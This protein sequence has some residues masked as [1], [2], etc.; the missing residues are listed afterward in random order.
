[1][2]NKKMTRA[3]L[4]G[5]VLLTAVISSKAQSSEFEGIDS[6][7]QANVNLPNAADFANRQTNAPVNYLLVDQSNLQQVVD[8]LINGGMTY[9]GV[10]SFRFPFGTMYGG[11]PEKT[12]AI[13]YAKSIGAEVVIY[14]MSTNTDTEGQWN[15]HN[16]YFYARTV[17]PVTP[18]VELPN[19]ITK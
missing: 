8:R 4:V 14:T 9:L 5:A 2:K 19:M 13:A 6:F 18:A 1:V 12:A 10:S 16:I 7:F 3:M 11:V 15:S 17:V